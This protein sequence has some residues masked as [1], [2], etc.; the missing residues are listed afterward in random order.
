MEVQTLE[1]GHRSQRQVC[2]HPGD[3]GEGVPGCLGSLRGAMLHKSICY[4]GGQAQERRDREAPRC[5]RLCV[6]VVL[7]LQVDCTTGTQDGRREDETE[8]GAEARAQRSCL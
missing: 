5:T 7:P 2:D 6:Q 1:V 4:V 3:T 8:S